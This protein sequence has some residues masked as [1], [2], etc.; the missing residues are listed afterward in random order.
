MITLAA[1]RQ[2]ADRALAAYSEYDF[3]CRISPCVVGE[4]QASECAGK[5]TVAR[6]EWIAARQELQKALGC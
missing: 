2:V 1:L 6:Q 3:Y 5:L 4:P